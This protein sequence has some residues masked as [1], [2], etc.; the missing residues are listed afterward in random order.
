MP[1][2][3]NQ[4]IVDPDLD[5]LI[6]LQTYLE[7]RTGGVIRHHHPPRP[8]NIK[9]SASRNSSESAERSCREGQATPTPTPASA[10]E[11]RSAQLQRSWLLWQCWRFP[12][13]WQGIMA[14]IICAV[15]HPWNQSRQHQPDR[16]VIVICP[17]KREWLAANVPQAGCAVL[18]T[19]PP[20][21]SWGAPHDSEAVQYRFSS[22]LVRRPQY[23]RL[24]P[25]WP[26]T[27]D[28]TI[29]TQYVGHGRLIV[30]RSVICDTH[31]SDHAKSGIEGLSAATRAGS[32]AAQMVSSQSQVL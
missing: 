2:V 14:D 4:L 23:D 21:R 12:D 3:N 1:G 29:R 20:P 13:Q 31:T 11:S 28:R 7:V 9:W 17:V 16:H 25:P 26:G 18:G 15:G 5:A 32:L 19:K 30:A 10:L 24:L 8:A 22:A 27:F 6:G